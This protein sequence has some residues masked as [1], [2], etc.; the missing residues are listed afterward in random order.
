M[1]VVRLD[2]VVEPTDGLMIIKLDAENAEAE[3]IQ[4]AMRLIET[5]K[6]VIILRFWPSG[7]DNLTKITAIDLLTSR[8]YGVFQLSSEGQLIEVTESLESLNKYLF[9]CIVLLHRSNTQVQSIHNT[10]EV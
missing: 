1:Q 9:E 4:G 7:R 10:S 6:P 8:D 5:Y 2:D 3:V